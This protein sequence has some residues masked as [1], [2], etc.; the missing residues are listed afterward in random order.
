VYIFH[1][2]KQFWGT[3]A[4]EKRKRGKENKRERMKKKERK[5][6]QK[7]KKKG[8][9]RKMDEKVMVKIKGLI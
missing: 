3:K 5:I 4:R 6:M 1:S 9:K 8:I 2:T 7:G